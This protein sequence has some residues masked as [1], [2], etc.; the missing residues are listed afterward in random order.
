MMF[1]FATPQELGFDPSVQRHYPT[2]GKEYFVFKIEETKN[3]ATM[4]IETTTEGPITDATLQTTR[5]FKTIKCLSEFKPLCITGRTT[6]VWLVEEVNSFDDLTAKQ[7]EPLRVLKDVW[8]N[9]EAKT[10][11]QIQDSIFADVEK[12]IQKF[13][14]EGSSPKIAFA[15]LSEP[16]QGILKE[17]F[18]GGKFKRH[19]LSICCDGQGYTSKVRAPSAR[20]CPELLIKPESALQAAQNATSDT[21]RCQSRTHDEPTQAKVDIP[22][23]P[24]F[25]LPRRQYRVVYTEVA[26]A[27]Q[28]LTS[29]HDSMRALRG[30]LIGKSSC[31]PSQCFADQDDRLDHH[32]SGGVGPP[33]RQRGKHSLVFPEWFRAEGHSIRSRVCQ[34]C[35]RHDIL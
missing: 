30:G 9:A 14:D 10:E 18:K 31:F 28:E 22:R 2:G 17:L 32:V 11:R 26:E 21:S 25:H 34:T 12:F 13:E 20:H 6:R 3:I 8:L 15:T 1:L 7:G 33:R 24:R 19:F 27:M 23:V 4:N 35:R 16:F 5:Y 29:F